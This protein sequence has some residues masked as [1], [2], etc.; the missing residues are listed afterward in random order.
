M[1]SVTET[2]FEKV[3]AST[4]K[5]SQKVWVWETKEADEKDMNLTIRTYDRKFNH[6]KVILLAALEYPA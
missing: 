6:E 5:K 3:V 4:G 1:E 2:S